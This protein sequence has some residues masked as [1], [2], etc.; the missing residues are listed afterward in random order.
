MTQQQDVFLSYRRDDTRHVAGR[1][2][3]RLSE[4]FRIFMDVDTI[5]P[6]TD[7]AEVVRE[8]VGRCD[9]LLAIVG[10]R[11]L[12]AED[13][14]G[15]RRLDIA[16]DWVVEEIRVALQR[17]VRVIPVLVDGAHMPEPDK[18][19]STIA[20]LAMRQA[21]TLHHESFPSDVLRL[22]ASIDP[23]VNSQVSIRRDTDEQ[24]N[25][26]S[27]TSGAD[28][29]A[30]RRRSKQKRGPSDSI[31]SA[32]VEAAEQPKQFP[33]VLAAVAG[34]GLVL[35]IVSVVAALFL[36]RSEPNIAITSP[37]S[38]TDVGANATASTNSQQPETPISNSAA[39][40]ASSSQ[41][42][43]AKEAPRVVGGSSK[44]Q[45]FTVAVT[46]ID[47]DSSR[48]V[49]INARVCVDRLP[50]NPQGDRTRVSWDPWRLS[51][52]NGS[53][54]ARKVAGSSRRAGMFPT[55]ATYKVGQCA[56][57]WIPFDGVSSVRAVDRISYKNGVGDAATWRVIN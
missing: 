53:Y 40:T 26:R 52:S 36:I 49:F 57:G 55:D 43:S 54:R 38:S 39:P 42:P 20:S 24:S 46:E 51:T 9:V 37:D 12:A 8:A 2:A 48:G 45:H 6:G 3:D 41:S 30:D 22:I 14:E 56:T 31:G 44:F 15:H 47:R 50:P 28:Q 34:L 4:H 25:D 11:W 23:D 16:G 27:G 13:L 32:G 35:L 1:L 33:R 29:A 19:P 18:L 5:Q 7:F 21:L 10:T 17:G